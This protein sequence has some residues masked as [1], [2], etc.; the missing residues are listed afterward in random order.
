[1]HAPRTCYNWLANILFTVTNA[2]SRGKCLY[3]TGGCTS[4]VRSPR[5][6]PR[7]VLLRSLIE[8]FNWIYYIQKLV[9]DSSQKVHNSNYETKRRAMTHGRN[10]EAIAS[11]EYW[12]GYEASFCPQASSCKVSALAAHIGHMR[13]SRCFLH[14]NSS[15]FFPHDGASD[16]GFASCLPYLIC[17]M[18]C[19]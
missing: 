4:V 18:L 14:T 12:C 2:E 9:A 7:R 8:T 13:V 16:T 3:E 11:G 5:G 17:F 10:D 1:M 19:I 6:G 15:G